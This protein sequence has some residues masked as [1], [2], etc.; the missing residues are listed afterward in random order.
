MGLKSL[1]FLILIFLAVIGYG[2][3][4][5]HLDPPFILGSVNKGLLIFVWGARSIF[6]G[7]F[8]LS[9]LF[10][11]LD[12]FHNRH[13]RAMMMEETNMA[14][15]MLFAPFAILGVGGF[16]QLFSGLIYAFRIVALPSIYAFALVVI[17]TGIKYAVEKRVKGALIPIVLLAMVFATDFLYYAIIA[18]KLI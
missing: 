15:G 5:R 7:A 3:Y 12:I 10:F 4:S 14:I 17:I 6:A 9:W 1:G 18:L 16:F 8:F 13:K 2:V 11:I